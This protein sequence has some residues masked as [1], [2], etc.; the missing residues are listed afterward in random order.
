MR[1]QTSASGSSVSEEIV[2]FG[3]SGSASVAARRMI[4]MPKPGSMVSILSQRSLV[5]RFTSRTES[6]GLEG[7]TELGDELADVTG[8]CLGGA[9]RLREDTA[10]LDE[11]RRPNRINR[12]A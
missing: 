4:S 6:F 3:A 12:L 2:C 11:I 5:R 1:P 10:D 8:N 7:L 9:D